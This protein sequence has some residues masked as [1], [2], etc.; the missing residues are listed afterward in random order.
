MPVREP[1]GRTFPVASLEVIRMPTM[2]DTLQLWWRH[3]NEWRRPERASGGRRIVGAQYTFRGDKLHAPWGPKPRFMPEAMRADGWGWLPD[4]RRVMILSAWESREAIEAHESKLVLPKGTERWAV[5]LRPVKIRGKIYGEQVLG[6]FTEVGGSGHKP[7]IGMTWNKHG[8]WHEPAFHAWIRKIADDSHE[9]PGVLASMSTGWLL[10]LPYFS[11]FTITCWRRLDDVVRFAYRR[12]AHA[13]VI[14]WY[15]APERFS[16]PWWGRFV[17]EESR[18]TLAGK[19]PFEGLELDP[20][21]PPPDDGRAATEAVA[22]P[23]G[24]PS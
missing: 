14:K 4:F 18:G 13:E 24:S 16:E 20:E 22:T 2:L 23:A 19:D 9:S 3:R 11:A 12:P 7:G 15:G 1:I 6:D 8:L 17:V 21:E 10:G 5:R